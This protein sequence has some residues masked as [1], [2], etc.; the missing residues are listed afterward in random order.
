MSPRRPGG[1]PPATQ[2]TAPASSWRGGASMGTAMPRCWPGGC[3]VLRPHAVE[4]CGQQSPRAAPRAAEPALTPP[5]TMGVQAG[6]RSPCS[7]EH[8][9]GKRQ[10]GP[11]PLRMR[12]AYAVLQKEAVSPVHGSSE[13]MTPI[14]SSR[15]GAAG[16]NL[17]VLAGCGGKCSW[18]CSL[19]QAPAHMLDP[20]TFRCSVD[21]RGASPCSLGAGD[22][23]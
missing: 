16:V 23:H 2:L 10:G 5:A 14:G 21:I 3:L 6:L 17:V 15:E 7:L 20:Q 19:S 18:L 11:R 1:V 22:A 4:G 8:F 9:S 13:H 12:L